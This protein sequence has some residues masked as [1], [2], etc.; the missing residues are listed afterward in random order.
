M[1]GSRWILRCR[2][3]NCKSMSLNRQASLK[4]TN[5]IIVET[6][7]GSYR[8][9]EADILGKTELEIQT[10][11]DVDKITE[12]ALAGIRPIWIH[13]NR[14]GSWAVAVGDEPLSWPE[15]QPIRRRSI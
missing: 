8:L 3:L 9:N 1:C 11:V 7:S 4:K 10:R 5:Q 14:D 12:P 2:S 15:D 13:K 6:G